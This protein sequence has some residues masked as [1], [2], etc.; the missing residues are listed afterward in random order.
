MF[1]ICCVAP[2]STS[3][4]AKQLQELTVLSEQMGTVMLCALTAHQ[5]PTSGCAKK[6]HQLHGNL[7]D[8]LCDLASVLQKNTL[9][10]TT[11]I[12]HMQ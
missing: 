9:C 2:R 11:Y 6:L 3:E 8:T 4:L 10:S 7:Q 1:I 12:P 5:A